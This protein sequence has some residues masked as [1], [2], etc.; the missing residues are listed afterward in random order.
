MVTKQT[1]F[2]FYFF[3]NIYVI[4]LVG[5]TDK[6]MNNSWRKISKK[7]FAE[8]FRYSCISVCHFLPLIDIAQSARANPVPII[9]PEVSYV[10]EYYPRTLQF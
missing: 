5:W 1:S 10:T 8:C 4:D 6:K 7:N 3:S 2:L 9:P